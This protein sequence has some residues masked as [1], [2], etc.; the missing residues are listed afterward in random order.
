MPV[1][2]KYYNLFFK[3]KCFWKAYSLLFHIKYTFPHNCKYLLRKGV[4]NNVVQFDPIF[5]SRQSE[6]RSTIL[7]KFVFEDQNKGFHNV[8]A[9]WSSG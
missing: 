3:K 4:K 7:S 2:E 9:Q 1:Q 5:V 8:E 6:L